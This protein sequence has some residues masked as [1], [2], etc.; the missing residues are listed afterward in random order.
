MKIWYLIKLRNETISLLIIAI[1]IVS[2]LI[3][4]LTALSFSYCVGLK[5]DSWL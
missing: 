3:G 5:F 2:N 1:T 4:A